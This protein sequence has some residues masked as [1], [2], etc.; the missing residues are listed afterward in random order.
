MALGKSSIR[1]QFES[2][3]HDHVLHD[4]DHDRAPFAISISPGRDWVGH[5]M[6]NTGHEMWNT[7]HKT[8]I[9]ANKSGNVAY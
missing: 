4:N 8:G 2:C 1:L 9:V 7:G 3:Y 6:W 5:E